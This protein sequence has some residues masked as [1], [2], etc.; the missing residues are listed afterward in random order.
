MVLLLSAIFGFMTFVRGGKLHPTR[1]CALLA[2]LTLALPAVTSATRYRVAGGIALA[3]LVI[4]PHLG[5]TAL[6]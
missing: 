3:V 6:R 4:A 1:A 2:A 5:G